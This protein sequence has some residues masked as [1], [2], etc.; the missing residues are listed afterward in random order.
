MLEVFPLQ[1]ADPKPCRVLIQT[2]EHGLSETA[3]D[4]RLQGKCQR[5]ETVQIFQG[6]LATRT[7]AEFQI[8]RL[9]YAHPTIK[10]LP[11]SLAGTSGGLS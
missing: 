8:W 6:Q 9:P 2:C 7:S 1:L 4:T 10:K 5:E 3:G 11:P